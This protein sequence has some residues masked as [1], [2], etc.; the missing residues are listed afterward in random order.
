[1]NNVKLAHIV[2][3]A[4][5]VST[6]SFNG[7]A[8]QPDNSL[9]FVSQISSNR[10]KLLP[11]PS[12]D[13]TIT[14]PTTFKSLKEKLE[15]LT[16][17]PIEGETVT[18]VVSKLYAD[19]KSAVHGTATVASGSY[20][21]FELL[22]A[23]K[24]IKPLNDFIATH[25]NKFKIAG[26]LTLGGLTAWLFKSKEARDFVY[27]TLTNQDVATYTGIAAGSAFALRGI[28]QLVKNG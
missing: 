28:E 23:L 8:V 22:Q 16:G 4:L 15:S 11:V 17:S 26:A 18:D 10:E 21:A 7:F 13:I 6:L 14:V 27:N 20:L 24:S 19:N 3:G 5:I 12:G 25:A 2:L 1:M 9:E